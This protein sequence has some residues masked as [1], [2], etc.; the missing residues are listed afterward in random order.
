MALTRRRLFQL[1]FG[2]ALLLGFGGLA[3]WRRS[4][5]RPI[6]AGLKVLGPRD[7]SV[8]AAVAARVS[9]GGGGWPTADDI[10][11]AQNVDALLARMDPTTAG[12]ILQLL[13]LL[14]NAL[15]GLVM[16]GRIGTFVSASDDAQ[17]RILAAWRDSSVTLRQTGFHALV[18]LCASAYY[19]DP[20]T[21]AMV[22]YPGPPNYGNFKPSSVKPSSVEP[23]SLKTPTGP[24]PAPTDHAEPT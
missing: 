22:G 6:P 17:D 13:G 21:Y 2:G 11:V 16:D 1:G 12:E 3:L 5:D 15:G 23:S 7:Y 8:L 9:P 18:G 24:T 10:G 4:G 14:D 20:R 19:A